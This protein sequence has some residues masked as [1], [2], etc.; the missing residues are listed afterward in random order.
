MARKRKLSSLE[1]LLKLPDEKDLRIAGEL[2]DACRDAAN[3]LIRKYFSDSDIESSKGPEELLEAVS[4]DLF[5][6]AVHAARILSQSDMVISKV[7]EA[8]GRNVSFP[9]R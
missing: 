8:Q 7:A 9:V 1:R 4:E 5:G 6:L 3:A 2:G